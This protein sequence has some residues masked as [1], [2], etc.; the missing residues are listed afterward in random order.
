M[1]VICFGKNRLLGGYGDRIVGLIAVQV[2]AAA[3]GQE[4]RILWEKEDITPFFEYNGFVL[5]SDEDTIENDLIDRQL[6]IKDYLM[7]TP[8]PFP[9]PITKFY[10]NQEIAQYIFKDTDTYFTSIFAAYKAL[11]TSTLKP[12]ARLL[13]KVRQYVPDSTNRI[14]GIQIRCGD[15]FMATNRGEWYNTGAREHIRAYLTQ[16]KTGLDVCYPGSAYSVFVTSDFTGILEETRNVFT[17]TTTNILYIDDVIQ[18]IDRQSVNPDISK[19]FA[20]NYI[21]SQLT[22]ELYI[23]TN[24]NY[25]RVA[26]LSAVHDRI[27]DVAL[28]SSPLDKRSLLTKGEMIFSSSFLLK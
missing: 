5:K 20:D 17:D 12:T 24:S 28:P 26:A 11:Y 19:V 3:L 8:N 10:L 13:E 16:I 2:M 9:D 18:H 7:T 6:H 25:G 15:C 22:T 23:S 4:F 14:I 27:Y 21:L 1:L